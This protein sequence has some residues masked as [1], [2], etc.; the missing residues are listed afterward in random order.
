MLRLCSTVLAAINFLHRF[1]S[2]LTSKRSP[3]LLSL[4]FNRLFMITLLAISRLSFSLIH[5]LIEAT[6]LIGRRALPERQMLDNLSV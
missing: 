2:P 5:S 1:G 3:T 4:K 6:K